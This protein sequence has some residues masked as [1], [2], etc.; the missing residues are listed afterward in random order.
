MGH[1]ELVGVKGALG[2]DEGLRAGLHTIWSTS[3]RT[4]LK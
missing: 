4:L 3:I 2:A 1:W